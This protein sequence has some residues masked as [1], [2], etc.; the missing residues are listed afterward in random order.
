MTIRSFQPGDLPQITAIYNHYVEHSHVTFDVAPR[1]EAEATAWAQKYADTG[2]NRLLVA[3]AAD[4]VVAYASSQPY[5]P[6][7][8]YATSVELSL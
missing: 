2:A 3:A 1:S 8:A 7:P 5:R 4:T 6:K